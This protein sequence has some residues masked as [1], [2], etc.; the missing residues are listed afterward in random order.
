MSRQQPTNGSEV[1]Y[2]D[3]NNARMRRI[4]SEDFKTSMMSP[5]LSNQSISTNQVNFAIE[6]KLPRSEF[7]E[8]KAKSF[9]CD[10]S[11]RNLFEENDPLSPKGALK[12]YFNAR[13]SACFQQTG[14]LEAYY[15]GL[16]PVPKPHRTAYDDDF[17]ES[18]ASAQA[19][20]KLARKKNTLEMKETKNFKLRQPSSQLL[21]HPY[22]DILA[23]C[24]NSGTVSVWDSQSAAKISEFSN[25]TPKGGRFTSSQWINEGSNSLLVTGCDD[26]SV[27]VWNGFTPDQTQHSLVSAFFGLPN[28]LPDPAKS[29]L[30]LEWQQHNGHL[31]AAGNSR[32]IHC[33]D[34]AAEKSKCYFDTGIEEACV[35][36]MASPWSMRDSA[37]ATA[38]GV[39][40]A[41]PLVAGF[42]DG[43]MKVYDVR[44][45]GPVQSLGRARRQRTT[46][47]TEHKSWIVSTA[48]TQFNSRP[49]IVTGGIVGDVKV[50]DLR[51]STSLITYTMQRTPMT[52]LSF[53]KKIP[54]V[55]SGSYAQ[56]VKL[57]SL[58]GDSL[59]VIRYHSDGQ[60]IGPVSCLAFHPNKV[61]LAAGGTD[62]L[63]SL[64]SPK[65]PATF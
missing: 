63:V 56:F 61:Q 29:G 22:E 44:V 14:R 43:S 6:F 64:Y 55:A 45:G 28:I 21:F 11:D 60:S 59:Q 17:L 54:V 8:W 20:E 27:R 49:E 48:F 1:N 53:H 32:S 10:S 23:V 30:I 62:K 25:G 24:D 31:V 26:G 47:Y 35:T 39:M 3:Q 36:S 42:S 34:M 12:S 16:A 9:A 15:S 4:S 58:D 38:S 51:Q 52:T 13:N 41:D 18:E 5:M 33:W 2:H 40:G 65:K 37:G 57:M 46:H 7:Y 50:W 19:E